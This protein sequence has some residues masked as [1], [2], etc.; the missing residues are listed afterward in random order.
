[1]TQPCRKI[2][3]RAHRLSCNSSP[4]L[5]FLVVH[6]G[7]GAFRSGSVS[8]RNPGTTHTQRSSPTSVCGRQG[9]CGRRERVGAGAL[10][11][12]P[13]CAF[14]EASCKAGLAPGDCQSRILLSR[15][16]CH[17]FLPHTRQG[18]PVGN[19]PTRVLGR[20][21]KSGDATLTKLSHSFL[22]RSPEE[23]RL[24]SARPAPSRDASSLTGEAIQTN[25]FTIVG[26]SSIC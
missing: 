12:R 18:Y 2:D 17:R 23:R 20:G 24:K 10:G 13:L 7:S 19:V 26:N 14:F 9:S 15:S 11:H 21:A 25:L 1:M 8:A 3:S 22:S 4:W 5:V 16:S 6:S